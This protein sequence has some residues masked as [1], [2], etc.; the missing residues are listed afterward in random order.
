MV[1]FSLS[2]ALF[3]LDTDPKDSVASPD[4]ILDI[5]AEEAQLD[6]NAT[7]VTA[8]GG[9]AEERSSSAATVTI[10]GHDEIS[11]A[12]WHSLGEILAN[13]PGLYVID[14]LV[15]PSVS[16]RGM[17]A[18]VDGGTRVLRVMIDSIQVN[19]RPEL[20]SFLG[21]EFLP[22]EVIDR[23]EIA[24]GP[25]SAVYGANAF[26]ATVNVITK[27]TDSGTRA[28]VGGR[29]EWQQA[30]PHAGYGG[31][32][33]AS[34]AN[35]WF[36]L[37]V[38]ANSYQLDRSGLVIPHT[39]ANQTQAPG[40]YDQYFLGPTRGDTASPA[41]GWLRLNIKPRVF[42]QLSFEGG[43]QNLD[44]HASF[45]LNSIP[46]SSSQVG[47][48]NLWTNL[49]HK[50]EW[51]SFLT[52][53]L[54]LGWSQGGPRP[55]DRL[56]LSPTDPYAHLPQYGYGALNAAASARFDFHWI[57]FKVGGDFEF[58]QEKVLWYQSVPVDPELTANT[59]R[60]SPLRQNITTGGA[61]ASADATPFKGLSGLRL[62]A[63]FRL[64]Y[65]SYGAFTEPVQYSWRAAAIYRPIDALVA[66]VFAG[67]AFQ[68]PSGVLMFAVPG[69]FGFGIENNIIGS[70]LVRGAVLVPQL[71]NS[72]EAAVV[73]QLKDI[74]SI[75]GSAF[76]QEI[77]NTITFAVGNNN[78]VAANS[79]TTQFVG[80]EG[81]AQL[82]WK[83]IQ[84]RI[85]GSFTYPLASS[86]KNIPA[87]GN[88][89][90]FPQF[91]LLASAG[92]N[93]PEAFLSVLAVGHIIGAR[94]ASDLNTL[95]NLAH[96]YTLPAYGDFDLVVSSRGLRFFKDAPETIFKAGMRNVL[97][98]PH[99]EPGFGG[100]DIPSLGRSLFFELR[101]NF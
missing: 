8:S 3:A 55:D 29:I 37:M 24:K 5:L 47:L 45:L 67:R 2:L 83:R 52:S 64:D 74:I 48:Y 81:T 14:D 46:T 94:G 93:I 13:V 21:P 34:T 39:F 99:P 40:N 68:G 50:K 98:M 90:L 35:D 82:A 33:V 56:F 6:V 76:F 96:F 26:L 59:D 20:T 101:Q 60:P 42:G 62:T 4:S 10:I 22:V 63:D 86:D 87:G 71:V 49:K 79:G 65:L 7:V 32:G 12:G 41:S 19:F 51:T 61:Y 44:S 54:S 89:P 43:I 97:N 95:S 70:S 58:D 17:S 88:I 75:E 23:V 30:S 100:Y 38:A 53:E 80:A 28:Q 57:G 16:V 36:D 27:T 77:D 1:L 25:L 15:T 73:G 78:L 31:S 84:A 66:K 11:K 85:A 9:K 69:E 72:I 92:C 91:Q 18:G